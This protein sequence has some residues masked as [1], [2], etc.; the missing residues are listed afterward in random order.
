MSEPTHRISASPKAVPAAAAAVLAAAVSLLAGC[1]MGVGYESPYYYGA[2][3]SGAAID[4]PPPPLPVYAQ[5]PCPGEG[6]LWTPGYWAYSGGYYWVPGTW[7]LPPQV[8]LLWTPGYWA[9]ADGV[10][11]WHAGYW[12][13]RVGFYGGVN[14]GFG[15]DGV[16][17]VGGRWDGDTFVYNRYVTNVNEHHIRHTYFDREGRGEHHDREHHDRVSYDGG[18][19]G[20]SARPTRED[21]IARREPHLPPTYSQREHLRT[22]A[23]HPDLFERANGGHPSIAATPRPG[24]F[25]APG[26]ERARGSQRSRH[27]PGRADHPNYRSGRQGHADHPNFRPAQPHYGRHPQ[28]YR[29]NPV[30]RPRS[31]PRPNAGERAAPRRGRQFRPRGRQASHGSRGRDHASRDRRHAR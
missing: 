8:G 23:H 4:V 18:R 21:R 20:I 15:Y 9:F 28:I 2:V 3:E 27:Q 24:V 6:Y 7:V 5:P 31:S 29:R 26:I 1:V 25:H 17:F 10:Y 13:R 12:G 19:D 11:L 30:Q 16:G 22:A 14:Y